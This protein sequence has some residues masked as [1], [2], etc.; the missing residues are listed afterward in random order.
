MRN[1][2]RSVVAVVLLLGALAG[3]VGAPTPA[4][5]QSPTDIS[6]DVDPPDLLS[7]DQPPVPGDG[8]LW[9]PGYWA[10]SDEDQDYYWVPGAWVLVP[11]PGLLWTPGYW[12]TDGAAFVW[13][14]GYWGPHVGFYGGV[15]YGFGFGG[16]GYEGAYWQGGRLFYNQAVNNVAGAKLA[17][18]Y[19]KP[20]VAPAGAN[21]TSFNGGERGT[22]A[23]PTATELA[24]A[25]EP[26]LPATAQ[27]LHADDQ[28][29]SAGVRPM[30]P[31]VQSS[32]AGTGEA[33]HANAPSGDAA[34]A[35]QAPAMR[36]NAPPR[37][38][39]T[40]RVPA[41]PQAVPKAQPKPAEKD[42]HDHHPA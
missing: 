6:V 26:H 36:E 17:N 41:P 35:H 18:V 2:V 29:R 9:S 42:E 4:F 13:F 3:A 19:S 27:Q 5:A 39:A 34:A 8:Y 24:A 40:P 33:L 20:V 22:R 25:R 37:P 30:R 11:Q 10:W 38:P 32:Y 21:H 14:A 23:Q 15:D 1:I 31:V 28:A 12:A 7:S 16:S